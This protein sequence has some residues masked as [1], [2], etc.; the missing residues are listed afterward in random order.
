MHRWIQNLRPY[1]RLDPPQVPL[2]FSKTL[3]GFKSPSHLPR[4]VNSNDELEQTMPKYMP[5][6]KTTAFHD[7]HIYHISVTEKPFSVPSTSKVTES[8]KHKLNVTALLIFSQPAATNEEVEEST[9]LFDSSS[10]M[11]FTALVFLLGFLGVAVIA[12]LTYQYW[13]F[14]PQRKK[15]K[16]WIRYNIFPI[17]LQSSIVDVVF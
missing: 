6:S 16:P 2:L 7:T 9:G 1:F 14:V 5:F 8:Q 12:G 4:S 13:M 15:G 17:V 3:E 10:D 11:F